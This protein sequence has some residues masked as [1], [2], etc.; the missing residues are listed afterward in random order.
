MIGYYLLASIAVVTVR[1][2]AGLFR[3]N[4]LGELNDVAD[5]TSHLPAASAGNE[6]KAHREERKAERVD[7]VHR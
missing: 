1:I 5:G 6:G 7:P 2:C 4:G 3:R